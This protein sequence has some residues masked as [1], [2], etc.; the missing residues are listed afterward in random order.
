MPQKSESYKLSPQQKEHVSIRVAILA[1]EPLGWGSGKH[2]FQ[3]ILQDY[4][5][6]T[7]NRIYLFQTN[8]IY[9]KEIQQ[10]KLSVDDYD[11]LLVPG[12]G[13]GDGESIIRG[14][15]SF[16]KNTK[17]KNKIRTYVVQGGSYI[18]ICGGSALLTDLSQGRHQ[19]PTTLIERL[20]S[21]SSL[22]VSCIKHYYYDL[23][24]PLFYPYQKK[25]PE[26]IGATGYVFSFAPGK[27]TD[28]KSIHSGGVPVDFQVSKNNPIFSDYP[29]STLRLRWWGGPGLVI[30]ENTNRT[31]NIIATYPVNDFSEDTTTQI[32]A[33]KYVGGFFGMLKGFFQALKEIKNNHREIKHLL[34]YTYFLASPWKK[35]ETYIHLHLAQK[36]CITT[37]IYPNEHQGR[38]LL[39]AAHP[40]YMVWWG[41]HIEEADEHNNISLADGLHQWKDIDPITSSAEKELT[42]SWWVVRRF[43]A[44]AAKVPDYELPPIEKSNLTPYDK[45]ALY[46]NIFWDGTRINQMKNI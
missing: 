33:W 31:I 25:Y 24:F 21:K 10:G 35:T 11:V 26:R 28:G 6:E 12:G 34:L 19:Q 22:N 46:D 29:D 44:W 5:W 3:R 30:P 43:A 9:D 13:V 37:E 17:W 39:C 7:K 8:Y 20:Y 4:S 36:P 41:G 27:T 16:G 14:L 23:A 32:K 15:P 42:H 1:D 18:G 45:D 40:E 2:Y 38:I